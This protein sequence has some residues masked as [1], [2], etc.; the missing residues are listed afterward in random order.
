LLRGLPDYY[1]DKANKA[2]QFAGRVVVVK[3]TDRGGADAFAE[4]DGLYTQLLRGRINGEAVEEAVLNASISRVLAAS[5]HWKE[6]L[7]AS[8]LP[9]MTVIISNTTEVGIVY[10][11]EDVLKAV[12]ESFPGKLLAILYQ[13]YRAYEGDLNKGFV[14]IPTELIPDNGKKLKS[15]VEKLAEHNHL[16]Q[17]FFDWLKNANS[18][19]SSLVD[20]IVPGKLSVEEASQ[21]EEELGY[22]DKLLIASEPY[23][24]WAI[25]TGNP[26]VKELLSFAR[27]DEGVVVAEDISQFRELKLR[28]LNGSHTLSCGLGVLSGIPLVRES[29]QDKSFRPFIDYLMFEELVPSLP[30]EIERDKAVGFARQV[31]DRYDNPFI[32][33]PWQSITLEYSKKIAMRTLP[34][35]QRFREQNG[36]VP[37][38]MAL[39][40][41][42]FILFMKG[43]MGDDGK[44]YGEWNGRSYRIDDSAAAFFAEAWEN[45]LEIAVEKILA[46]TE[47][48]QTDLSA[49]KEWTDAVTENVKALQAGKIDQLL[50]AVPSAKTSIG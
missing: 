35:L 20:R 50:K 31:L 22:T 12:P 45:E 23:G 18:F 9:E 21:K 11:E 42:G 15:I 47:L 25:E 14:I 19:C 48:W 37:A 46:H 28:L 10:Q 7:E 6:I 40:W 39:G 24:L 32:D 34:L 44:Y 13:R 36:T 4:Q 16:P 29:M 43:K 33:H 3:S 27:A 2:G 8:M 41:A 26:S 49:W 17:L 5:S 1:I 38:A 30:A